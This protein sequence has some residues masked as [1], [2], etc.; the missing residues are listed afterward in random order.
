MKKKRK[1]K[2]VG[3]GE[4]IRRIP[5]A[6]QKPR[7]LKSTRSR[8]L[9]HRDD[10]YRTFVDNLTDFIYMIDREMKVLALNKS[11]A[12]FL[13]YDPQEVIGKSLSDIFPENIAQQYTSSLNKVF[14]T[15][16]PL[17]TESRI[18]TRGMELITNVQLS[19]IKDTSGTTIA[20]M[21]VTR[22][23]T[24]RKRMELLI[25]QQLDVATTLSSIQDLTTGLSFCLDTV[26]AV[27]H[28]DCGTI[29]LLDSRSKNFILKWYQGLAEQFITG[30]SIIPLDSLFGRT[31]NRGKPAY[32]TYVKFQAALSW[33]E[34]K[35]RL[36]AAAIIP[37]LSKQ[38]II[39]CFTIAS[40]TRNDI[41]P[42]SR[43]AV[44]MVVAQM[45]NAIT[46]LEAEVELHNAHR[47]LEHK[48]EERT[49]QLTLTNRELK[50]EISRRKQT[51]NNLL[52][53]ERFLQDIFD[54]IQD[55][56]SILD[57]KL[58][59]QRAN[60]WMTRMYKNHMPLV[61]KKC[62]EVYQLRDTVCPWCPSVVTVK[63]GKQHHEIV[64]YPSE[65][66]P[67]KW[68]DVSSY[69]LFNT[70]GKV[71]GIIEHVRDITERRRGEQEQQ[72]LY[73]ELKASQA[74]LV[75][76]ERLKTMGMMAAGVAHELNNPMMGMINFVQYCMKHT[77]PN[78]RIYPVL[79]DLEVETR[80][81]IDIVQRLLTF[82]HAAKP[83]KETMQKEDI[84]LVIDRVVRLLDYRIKEQQTT[85]TR[86]I[87]DSIPKVWIRVSEI[88][89]VFLNIIANALDAVENTDR[90]KIQITIKPLNGH[91]SV[92]V[93]DTGCGMTPDQLRQIFDP[94]FSTKGRKQGTGLGLAISHNI[95]KEHGGKITCKSNAGKGTE[96]LILLPQKTKKKDG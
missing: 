41:A 21:G 11:A 47:I 57:T 32:G 93:K 37:I 59:I 76:L 66:N 20:V 23:I 10:Q 22:D 12:S 18:P 16:T 58:V 83:K 75:R 54:G 80:R 8:L 85:I 68:L 3:S 84:S 95:I 31:V 39:G 87:S 56:I 91:V 89:Q 49:K 30:C 88:Q 77:P 72:R 79:Y 63:T 33:L 9:F 25:K 14:R 34:G 74:Q 90:K 94:F 60:A 44:E 53:N 51:Q 35:N 92:S 1:A 71:T 2:K 27:S 48:V 65:K 50:N 24:Q 55:G 19:P 69:P 17:V 81:C 62:H 67:E 73:S 61:G 7:K 5:R 6:E 43:N 46:R 64:P 15:S 29:H 52:K 82:S 26:I 36:R 96:M 42:F 28:M 45:G 78:D 86:R 13:Q 4:T 70:R 38:R 40:H